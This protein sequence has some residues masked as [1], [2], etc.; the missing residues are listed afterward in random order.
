MSNIPDEIE[1]MLKSLSKKHL[2]SKALICRSEELD[3]DSEYNVN[4]A[5]EVR[6]A[7][8]HGMRAVI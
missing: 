4:V 2:T 5:K 6:D 1:E 3:P 7:F 8:D